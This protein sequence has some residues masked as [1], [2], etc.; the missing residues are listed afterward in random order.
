MIQGVIAGIVLII[1]FIWVLRRLGHQGDQ[2]WLPWELRRAQLVYA[3]QLFKVPAPV[4]LTARVDRG[5][6]NPAGIIV[7]VEL[8]TRQ[9]DRVYRSDVIELSA[10]RVAVMAQTGEQ[11][12]LYAYVVVQGP[13]GRRVAHRTGLLDVVEV[14]GL[15]LRR[16]AILIRGTA[17]RCSRSVHLCRGCC[18]QR[19]CRNL[20]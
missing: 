8:K 6:R 16:E 10:Q 15:I 3:E 12:A 17:P 20:P 13:S 11:V 5:Y 18:F 19:R 1:L 2:V 9:C 4:A 7:L 14:E